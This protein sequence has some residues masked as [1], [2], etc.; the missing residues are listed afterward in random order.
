MLMEA[1]ADG[2]KRAGATNKLAWF[3]EVFL[4]CDLTTWVGC[5]RCDGRI[6]RSRGE[7]GRAGHLPG[8]GHTA[9]ELQGDLSGRI[10]FWAF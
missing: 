10:S 7:Q 5:D 6:G 1:K 8:M 9:L 3:W 2:S 4:G